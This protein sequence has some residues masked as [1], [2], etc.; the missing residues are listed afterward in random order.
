MP[1]AQPSGTNMPSGIISSSQYKINN[2]GARGAID[3][4]TELQCQI[5]SLPSGFSVRRA[6]F[7]RFSGLL[8]NSFTFDLHERHKSLFLAKIS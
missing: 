8:L 2:I 6:R 1:E 5:F 7:V 3:T 4:A